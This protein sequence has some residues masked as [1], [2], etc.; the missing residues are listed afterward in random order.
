MSTLWTGLASSMPHP[1]LIESFPIEHVQTSTDR[2]SGTSTTRTVR[3]R[4]VP[5]Q[6]PDGWATYPGHQC[7]GGQDGLL[8]QDDK[9]RWWEQDLWGA[10]CERYCLDIGCY[11][12]TAKYVC[13]AYAPDWHGEQLECREF[14][15]A[16]EAAA[17][18]EQWMA[19]NP[20]DRGHAVR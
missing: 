20:L 16:E 6:A 3:Y 7:H 15:R 14:V 5:I 11:G 19:D 12:G 10:H 2:R 13:Y 18:A 1:H 17:W 4:F 9:A 8:I